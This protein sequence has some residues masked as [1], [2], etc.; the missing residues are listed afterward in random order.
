M[1]AYVAADTV[2]FSLAAG[3]VSAWQYFTV[4]PVSFEIRIISL[5]YGFQSVGTTSGTF[6]AVTRPSVFRCTGSTTSG[7][8]SVPPIAMRQG[9]PT[10]SATSRFGPVSV[11]GT[12][13]YVTNVPPLSVGNTTTVLSADPTATTYSFPSDFTIAP[14]S[15]FSFQTY[16]SVGGSGT[17]GGDFRMAIYFEE[18]RLAWHY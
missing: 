2:S 16:F 18:L 3:T 11:S 8:S 14:G 13:V 7:G 12:A 15:V 17:I 4:S 9:A 10:P 1:T 6:I 5:E